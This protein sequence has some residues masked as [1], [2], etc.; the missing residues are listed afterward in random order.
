MAYLGMARHPRSHLLRLLGFLLFR[1]ILV[2][3]VG[4]A[5][6]GVRA[7]RLLRLILC[8]LSGSL[9]FRKFL[10]LLCEGVSLSEIVGD[11]DIVEDASALP[12][13]QIEAEE[14]KVVLVYHVVIL[15]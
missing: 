8:L 5:I 13:P 11:D 6:R 3:V 2:L 14:T 4:C 9:D 1:I 7:L 10:P 15:I 12:L